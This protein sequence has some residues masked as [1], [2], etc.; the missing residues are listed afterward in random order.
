MQKELLLAVGDERAASYTL[1]Y[2]K[3]VYSDFCDL[4]LT[5][6]YAA[7]RPPSREMRG[8]GLTPS[9]KGLQKLNAAKRTKGGKAI[10]DS[11]KWLKNIVG[12]PE[13]NIRTKVVNSRKGIVTELVDEARAGNYDALL[14]GRRGFSWFEEMFANSVSHEL[15][16]HDID[17]PLWICRRPPKH[18]RQDVLLCLDGSPASLRMVDHAGYML[19]Q[20]TAHTFTLFHVTNH[21][22]DAAESTRVFDKGLAA[23]AGNNIAEERI[24]MKLVKSRNQVK[25]I[26]KEAAQG[27]YLAVGLGRHGE[28]ERSQKQHLFPDS[29]CVNLLRQMEN[30]TLW[31]SK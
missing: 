28:Y 14:L 18:P 31:I 29:T 3:E 12:C 26:L 20:E 30:T 7:P 23:L 25:A 9:G 2:L 16:W 27:N 4:R 11:L 6:F 21:G 13:G 22:F 8:D 24:E 5:L 10:E 1:R 19:A 17:F 15:L